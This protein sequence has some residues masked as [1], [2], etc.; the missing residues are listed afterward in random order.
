MFHEE[1]SSYL[2]K[3][4]RILNKT[5]VFSNQNLQYE[6]ALIDLKNETNTFSIREHNLYVKIVQIDKKIDE[7]QEEFPEKS[8]RLPL[9]YKEYEALIID[10]QNKRLVFN[11]CKRLLNKKKDVL[12]RKINLINKK[13]VF[14]DKVTE[15]DILMNKIKFFNLKEIHWLITTSNEV[16]NK[17]KES[18]AKETNYLNLIK[19]KFMQVYNEV[20]LSK[21]V[22]KDKGS[23]LTAIDLNSIEALQKTFIRLQGIEVKNQEELHSLEKT[24]S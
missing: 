5:E 12:L 23:H 21:K 9:L 3:M 8:R 4:K 1:K 6:K 2:K 15:G 19:P 17:L 20:E 22:A 16:M 14:I 13:I 11:N 10:D 24:K 7:I 18:I